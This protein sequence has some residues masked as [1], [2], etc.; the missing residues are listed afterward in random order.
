MQAVVDRPDDVFPWDIN[1]RL[2]ALTTKLRTE[3]LWGPP[4][5]IPAWPDPE[6]LSTLRKLEESIGGPVPK[7][8]KQMLTEPMT[9]KDIAGWFNCGRNEVRKG[10]LAI[11]WHQKDGRKY[12]MQTTDMPA[13]YHVDRMSKGQPAS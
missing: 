5:S 2:I 9:L 4:E 1:N 7:K 13:L 8:E 10:V 11:Y 12:R 6:L 3:Y